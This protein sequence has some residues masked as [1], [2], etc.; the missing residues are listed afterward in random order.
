MPA[1]R[2][3]VAV[4]T[5][6]GIDGLILAPIERGPWSALRALR[7]GMAE[8]R[9]GGREPRTAFVLAI[10]KE[11]RIVLGREARVDLFVMG[12]RIGRR[13]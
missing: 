12:Y 11:G 1:S 13:T 2:A 8:L 9:R 7:E 5:E 6:R 4:R 10:S 3:H